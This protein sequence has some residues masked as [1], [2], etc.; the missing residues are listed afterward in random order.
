VCLR[1]GEATATK[2]GILV[3]GADEVLLLM[4]I[5]PWKTP[6]PRELSEAWAYAPENPD[7]AE[8]NLGRYVAC[9]EL[10]DSSV[11]AFPSVE[12]AEVLMAQLVA[13][14]ER[15]P[16]D[17][18]ELLER[19]LALHR[20]LF[21]RVRLDLRAP[22]EQ[23]RWT[24]E[25]LLEDAS[26]SGSLSLALAEKIHDA[27]RYMFLC[28]A[29]ELPPNLQ[30]IWTGTW[31]PAWS[32]DFTLDTNLQLALKHG[33]SGGYPELMEGYFRLMESFQPEWRLN[34]RRTYGT[35]GY[36]TNARAS[37]TALLLHWG[38]WPGV[39]W[40]AGCGWLVR[41]FYEHY[42]YTGDRRFLETRTV[43]FLEEVAAF[44]ED[45]VV[46]DESTGRIEF[47]PSY[48]PETGS[49]TSATM[50]VMVMRD[51]LQNL[52]ASYRALGSH[53]EDIPR[54]QALL[55]R[56]PGCRI[57]ED[58]AL[59]EWIPDGRKERY[60]HRHLS[61]LHAAYEANGELGP[62]AAPALRT[63]AQEA[64]RRRIHSGGEASSH[65]RAHM[66]LAA[67][68]LDLA[69]EAYGRIEA[70][71]TGRSMTPSLMC[72]HEPGGRIFNVDANGAMPEIMYRMLFRARPGSI[73]LLPA[74]PERWPAGEINGVRA[75]GRITIVR[76][77]WDVSSRSATC[78]LRS[79]V[80][81]TV[82]VELPAHD[83]TG[84]S[85]R[86]LTLEADENL[87]VELAW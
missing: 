6:L 70:M 64:V 38:T 80:D 31:R 29:G 34:A 63:A 62:G 83:P 35:D 78:V 54:W 7:F 4:R 11:V 43:P 69:A 85:A 61:H 15:V 17:Y 51:V 42:L 16:A 26:R 10:A 20:P 66:G 1:G 24:S 67:A 86:S 72:T 53:R 32:G 25:R 59:A 5:A 50:D 84:V 58:G 45:F 55:A 75:E 60:G 2:G 37:N 30:G 79:Q 13:S 9:P 28:C 41:P 56:L 19:H 8:G 22:Q 39:F 87:P 73:Q 81:Q 77:A 49:C 21:E 47:I 18:D 40:T 36:L 82:T 76:L 44:Y 12:A 48:S 65:G 27:G 14:L 3:R 23:R 71:A 52:I 33:F 68:E 46:I 74:L 57:N